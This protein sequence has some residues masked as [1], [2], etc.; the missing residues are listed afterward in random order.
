ME[1]VM[2]YGHRGWPMASA[3]RDSSRCWHG[4]DIRT[5]NKTDRQQDG[6][7]E[8]IMPLLQAMLLGHK[9]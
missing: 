2:G 4:T 1:S 6:Q 8:N 5:D 9:I 3:A 7:G